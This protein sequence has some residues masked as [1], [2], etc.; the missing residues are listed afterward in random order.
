MAIIRQEVDPLEVTRIIGR[1]NK[2]AQAVILQEVE[3]L[4][5]K[6]SEEYQQLRKVILDELNTLSR[7]YIRVIFGDIEYLV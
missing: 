2:R 5:D 3:Q 7:S 6:N 1:K 4:V